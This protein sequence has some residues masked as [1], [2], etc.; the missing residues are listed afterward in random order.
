MLFAMKGLLAK[1]LYGKGVSFESLVAIRAALALP[2]F[3]LF[4]AHANSIRTVRDAPRTAIAAAAAAGLLCYYAG[5]LTDFY[6][7]TLIDAS[8][9]RVLLFSYPAM[10][11]VISSVMTRT[12]P[13]AVIV[14][15]VG[16]TY[17]GIFLAVGGFEQHVF[18]DNLFGA[19]LVL[20]SGLTYAIY[21]LIAARY[22]QSLGSSGFTLV[23]MTA[24]G[25]ALIVHWLAFEPVAATLEY[26]SATWFGLTIL[27]IA[28]MFFPA[29]MQAEGLKRIGAQRGSVASTMGPPTTIIL[30]AIFLGER[31]TLSQLVGVGCIIGGV[32]FLDLARTRSDPD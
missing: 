31:L 22:T 23:G 18:T 3:W 15:A 19:A 7:L 14:I 30:A 25:I 20:F 13:T 8:I 11:V 5:A 17:F 9:E 29:L 10:V 16:I 26:D 24:A 6:A 12:W 1:W 2:L 28:C 21:F 4:A 32:L 27:A